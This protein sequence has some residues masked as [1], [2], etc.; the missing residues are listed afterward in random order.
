MIFTHLMH[1]FDDRISLIACTFLFYCLCFQNSVI[2]CVQQEAG[3]AIVMVIY[4]NGKTWWCYSTPISAAPAI[5]HYTLISP[6]LYLL[7]LWIFI[8]HFIKYTLE[9]VKIIIL[10]GLFQ[11]KVVW[12]WSKLTIRS[13]KSLTS[14][15]DKLVCS[16]Y[17][18]YE[19][20]RNPVKFYTLPFV[21]FSK[22]STGKSFLCPQNTTVYVS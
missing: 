6:H 18:Q 11:P 10:D 21:I 7:I 17:T 13:L 12:S 22:I 8:R 9:F 19:F 2:Y 15:R 1:Q 4:Q 3:G 14:T 16:L 20:I 5:L